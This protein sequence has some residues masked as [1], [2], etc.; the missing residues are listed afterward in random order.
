MTKH[1]LL[2]NFNICYRIYMY[3]KLTEKNGISMPDAN[4]MHLIIYIFQ[5]EL[6]P[7]VY[8]FT[9]DSYGK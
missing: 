9:I 7:H 2:Y 5:Q 8:Y 3:L 4:T 1:I 6:L